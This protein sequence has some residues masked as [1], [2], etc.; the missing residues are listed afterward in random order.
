MNNRQWCKLEK[1]LGYNINQQKKEKT[2]KQFW[3]IIP[4]DLKSD[5]KG[6]LILYCRYPPHPGIVGNGKARRCIELK[7]IHYKIF[8][9]EGRDFY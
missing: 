8:R 2:E 5:N 7:C 4:F 1:E 3:R 6:K 9:H